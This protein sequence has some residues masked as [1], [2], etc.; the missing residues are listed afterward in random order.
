MD[1][2]CIYYKTRSDLTFNTTEHV[3]S[4]GLGDIMT[5]PKGF[6]SLQFN[7]DISPVELRFMRESLIALPRQI[8]G[9]GKK[10][11]QALNTQPNQK[12]I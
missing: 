9:P 10:A 6:V 12:F 11:N 4:A 1:N 2:Q 7:N 5:L 8:L 3:F